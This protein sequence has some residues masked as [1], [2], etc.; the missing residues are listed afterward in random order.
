MEENQKKEV[1]KM[2]KNAEQ[3]IRELVEEVIEEMTSTGAVSV[4]LSKNAFG[5]DAENAAIRSIPGGSLVKSKKTKKDNTSV[6]EAEES[7]PIVRRGAEIMEGRY[8][9]LKESDIMR[10][11]SKINLAVQEAKKM[12]KEVNF[13]LSI[14]ERLKL[15]CGISNKEYLNRTVP[16]LMEINRQI[17][18]IAKRINRIRK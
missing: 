12:L 14:T 15:E 7:L 1:N 13:L 2:S 11:E 8:R 9:N 10:N 18:E 5:G 17:K 4:P 6:E 16:N 3:I